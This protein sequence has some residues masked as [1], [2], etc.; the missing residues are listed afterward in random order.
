M[1]SPRIRLLVPEREHGVDAHGAPRGHE[2]RQHRH[3]REQRGRARASVS[4]SCGGRPKSCG[5]Q[6]AATAPAPAGRPRPRPQRA[7]DAHLAQH[8]R[9]HA[10]PAAR[11][12]PGGCRSRACAGRPSSSSRRRGPTAA[13][14]VAS[15]PNAAESAATMRSTNSDSLISASHRLQVVDRA[16]ADRGVPSP[17]R[18]AGITA[19]S[20][21][22]RAHVEGEAGDALLLGERHVDDARHLVAQVV[23][24]RVLHEADDL[25]VERRRSGAPQPDAPADRALA[26]EEEA[27]ERLVDDRDL[28]RVLRCR[29]RRSRGRPPPEP[30]GV[31]EAGSDRGRSAGSCPR[32]PC[33]RGPRS[34]PCGSRPSSS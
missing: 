5:G 28:R 17:A 16:S 19:A 15:S 20:R 27:R 34:S 4:G 24:L 21:Q 18:T 13:S 31:H 10:A 33:A 1:A 14:S 23:G 9:Q 11:P 3:A 30:D 26:A 25:E 32:P 6:R 12:A 8:H 7:Q 22:A 2:A 29:S